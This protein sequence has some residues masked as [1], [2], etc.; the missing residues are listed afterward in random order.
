MTAVFHMR[1]ERIFKL[2][3]YSVFQIL[4]HL[5]HF[6][7]HIFKLGIISFYEVQVSMG[8]ILYEDSSKHLLK[9]GTKWLLCCRWG[10]NMFRRWIAFHGY[11]WDLLR[12]PSV[13]VAAHKSIRL[14]FPHLSCKGLYSPLNPIHLFGHTQDHIVSATKILI[15]YFMASNR[16]LKEHGNSSAFLLCFLGSLKRG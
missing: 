9:T 3:Q 12:L 1:S 11:W 5:N 14:R 8:F 15:K 2:C 10:V 13:I 4:N 7:F 16:V 6:K